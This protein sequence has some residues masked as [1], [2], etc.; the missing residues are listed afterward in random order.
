MSSS[1]TP[2]RRLGAS[3]HRV[4]QDALVKEKKAEALN[5]YPSWAFMG[6]RAIRPKQGSVGRRGDA[7]FQALSV[8]RLVGRQINIVLL[9]SESQGWSSGRE[10]NL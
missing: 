9:M 8:L 10:P 3:R 7:C 4:I 1:H 6:R 2:V 5:V